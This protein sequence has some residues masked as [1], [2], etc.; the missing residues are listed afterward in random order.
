MTPNIVKVKSATGLQA[1]L[2]VF[3]SSGHFHG[4]KQCY[5]DHFCP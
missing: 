1:Q 3:C 5:T 2:K 4:S